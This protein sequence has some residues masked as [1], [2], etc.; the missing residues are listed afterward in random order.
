V[1]VPFRLIALASLAMFVIAAPARSESSPARL[2]ADHGGLLAHYATTQC[3][4]ICPAYS[5]DVYRDG[6]VRY[7]GKAFVIHRG[8]ATASLP[9]T[10]IDEIRSAFERAAFRSLAAHCCDCRT[11]TDAQAV[12][13]AIEDGQARVEI[14]HYQGCDKEPKALR[15]LEERFESLLRVERWIGTEEQRRAHTKQWVRESRGYPDDKP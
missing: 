15:T 4:G 1:T 11:V 6:F 9:A 3:Y 8:V 5:L 7:E 13:V 12:I 2:G 10:T 14:N